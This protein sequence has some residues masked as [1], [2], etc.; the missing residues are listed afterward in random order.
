MNI[1]HEREYGT[2]M[3]IVQDDSERRSSNGE[4]T[5]NA[6][7]KEQLRDSLVAA[8]EAAITAGG[9]AAVRARD[10]AH[11]VGCALGA[12]YTVFPD[13]DALIVAVNSRTLAMLGEHLAAVERGGPWRVQPGEPLAVARL[14]ALA[15]GYLAFA[16]ANGPR[17]RALFAHHNPAG[18][19]VPAWHVDEQMQ[20]FRFIDA[21]LKEI[22]P[23]IDDEARALLGRSLF[24]AVHGI[25]SLGLEEKLVAVPMAH[26]REQ[27]TLVVSAAARGLM[28]KRK[29]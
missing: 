19:P 8:A 4:R 11:N 18:R 6:E 1:V 27:L 9:L 21:P 25:V 3:N 5:R 29:V 17:W 28:E 16:D 20:L 26:L 14:V 15:H 12:I 22:V 13:L 2:A 10:L 23:N 7:R 24:S